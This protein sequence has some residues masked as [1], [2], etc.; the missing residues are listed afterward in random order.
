MYP[1]IAVCDDDKNDSSILKSLI[2]S[3]L[4]KHNL[5]AKIDT[6]SSGEDFLASHKEHS[7]DIVFM[8]I[9]LGKVNGIEAAT[10]IRHSSSLTQII[11]TTETSD[12]AIE[13]FGL[14][15]SHYLLKPL[16]ESAIKEAMER[17]LS[18]IDTNYTKSLEIKTTNGIIPVPIKNITYIEVF[19]KICIVHTVKNIFQTYSSLD[20]MSELLDNTIF[21][22]AQRS[23]LVNMNFIESFFFDHI[24]LY[25]G[26]EIIL[27]RSNRTEL[28]KQYQQ[29]LFSLA[30]REDF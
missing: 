16:T 4:N 25:N 7:Y 13:A 6:F 8:D 2:Y 23:F 18:K 14:N 15:A 11:F 12:Y 24:I 22:R 29:F 19:N 10:T 17:C 9:Y 3:F 20:A 21:I 27:S 30:R 26:V 5:T 1:N 28:K